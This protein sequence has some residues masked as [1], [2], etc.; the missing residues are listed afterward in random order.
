V[1][2]EIVTN[3]N[4]TASSGRPIPVM[5]EEFFIEGAY[6]DVGNFRAAM[7]AIV[8]GGGY[9][10]AASL[11]WWIGTAYQNASHFDYS[12]IC[13][14]FMTTMPYWEMSPANNLKVSGA[15]AYVLAKSGAEYLAYLPNGGTITLNLS[16]APG[17]LSAKW[18]NPRTGTTTSTTTVTGGGNRSFT[19]PTAGT[20]TDWLLHVSAGSGSPPD[21]M[22]P[23][24]PT[25]LRIL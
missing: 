5:N 4:L 13:Y 7:W 19:S 24:A 15:T 8:M 2:P 25:G 9:F 20:L 14:D 23:A 12:M 21:L 1:N 17:S 18:F 22:P 16:S 3:R 11:G 6:G 10:K